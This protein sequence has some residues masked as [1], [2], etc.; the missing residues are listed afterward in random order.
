M[1][2]NTF[3]FVLVLILLVFS[4]GMPGVCSVRLLGRHKIFNVLSYGAKADGQRDDSS[5]FLAAWHAACSSTGLPVVYVPKMTFLINPVIFQGP[6]RNAHMTMQVTGKLIAPTDNSLW[7]EQSKNYWLHFMN[8]IGLTVEGRGILDGRGASWWTEM[9]AKEF[10]VS[11][12]SVFFEKQT[13]R[14]TGTTNTIVRKITSIN[15]KQFHVNFDT[16]SN[17][18]VEGVTIK[19]PGD[20][21]NTDGIHVGQSSNVEIRNILVGTGDD[22]ISIGP[23]SSDVAIEG[24]TCG[25]GHGISIGSL[26]EDNTL[27]AV[28]NITVSGASLYN[29][30]NG[31]RI[32]TWRGGNGFA[33]G[34]T[35]QNVIMNNVQNPIIIDQF[36][37]PYGISTQGNSGVKISNVLYKNITGTSAAN[38]AISFKCSQTVPCQGIKV[39]DIKLSYNGA[40][41]GAQFLCM[42]AHVTTSDAGAV[43]PRPCLS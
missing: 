20:S 7:S 35:F 27:A 43:S 11:N 30:Q 24:V 9:N 32:K 28:K 39:D 19:A 12:E 16:C 17:V 1:T 8:V 37:S 22:C 5:A 6:C 10:V 34:I 25:P 13:L 14:F 31:V 26:G 23:G 21:P 4:S 36:Y 40:T 2:L 15:S 3:M 18:V 41:K 29:T 42:N 33:T 38:A